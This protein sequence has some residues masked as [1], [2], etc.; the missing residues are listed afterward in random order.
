MLDLDIWRMAAIPFM[1]SW[2]DCHQLQLVCLTVVHRSV[3][4]LQ[5]QT[6]QTTFWHIWSVTAPSPHSA[7]I[8]YFA[9]QLHFL[10]SWNN[11]AY[12]S[13]N[14]VFSL[15][16]SVLNWLFKNLPILIK[17]FLIVV[18]TTAVTIQLSQNSLTKLFR[19]MLKA[20]K[21]Y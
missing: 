16:F 3:R 18:D 7:Q 6:L 12:Y 5:H 21:R 10:L 1:I 4:N 13:E 19:A 9:F 14:V 8:F 15:P 11:K 2:F 20:T 17:L